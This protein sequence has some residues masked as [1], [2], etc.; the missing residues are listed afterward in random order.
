MDMDDV[1]REEMAQAVQ[2]W[3][4][5]ESKE[6]KKIEKCKIYRKVCL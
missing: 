2:I 6:D 1:I 3:R 4:K 5:E